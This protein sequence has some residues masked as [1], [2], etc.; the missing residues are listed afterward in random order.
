MFRM[1]IVYDHF[2]LWV[3]V[4]KIKILQYTRLYIESAEA[5]YY[6]VKDCEI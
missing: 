1:F 6:L 3:F 2:K 5:R 4:I